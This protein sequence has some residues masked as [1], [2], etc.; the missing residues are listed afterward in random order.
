[1]S[2]ASQM[3]KIVARTGTI[4]L[5]RC[6]IHGVDCARAV[7]CWAVHWLR[8]ICIKKTRHFWSQVVC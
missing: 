4:H 7:R 6:W 5:D 1:M 8:I 3:R 2:L